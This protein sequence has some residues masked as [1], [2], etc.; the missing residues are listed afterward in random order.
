MRNVMNQAPTAHAI[1][2]LKTKMNALV[3][4]KSVAMRQP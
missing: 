1:P 3:K 4:Y 2:I